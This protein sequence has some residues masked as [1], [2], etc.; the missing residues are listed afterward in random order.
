MKKVDKNA[1]PNK[2]K[3]E[4]AFDRCKESVQELLDQYQATIDGY[5]AKMVSLKKEGRLAEADRY[6]QKLKLVLGRQAKMNELMDQVEQFS[7][8]IDEAFAKSA[9]Y[10]ALGAVMGETNKINM[11]PEIK[12]MLKQ[13]NDFDDIFSKGLNK[14]D[15]IFGKVS[16]KISDI[17]SD[18][19]SVHDKEIDDIVSKRLDQYDHQTTVEAEADNDLFKLN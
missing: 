3:I 17:D 12:K 7:Y 6:K 9:V 14:M 16:R 11:S 15:S 5:L 18:M 1:K 2:V 10:D 13:V 4:L 19:S 8:M